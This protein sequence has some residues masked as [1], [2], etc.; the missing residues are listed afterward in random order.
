VAAGSI[1]GGGACLGEADHRR[2]ARTL[3]FSESGWIV[4]IGPCC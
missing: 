1:T 3:L 2:N 4:S